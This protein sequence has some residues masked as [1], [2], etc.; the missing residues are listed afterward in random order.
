MQLYGV[1]NKTHFIASIGHYD[2]ITFEDMLMDGGQPGC[3]D[4]AGYSRFSSG[5][6]QVYAEVVQ[7]FGEL[8]TDYKFNT[9]ERKYGVWRLDDVRLLRTEKYP[10]LMSLDWRM[11]TSVWGTRGKNKNQPL[12]YIVLGD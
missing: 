4:Y 8:Y 5:N 1:K 11:K 9:K 6:T 12:K 3:D 2:C 7:T 10:D